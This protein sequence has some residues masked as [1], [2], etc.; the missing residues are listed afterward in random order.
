MTEG[1]CMCMNDRGGHVC[2]IREIVHACMGEGSWA[3]KYMWRSKELPCGAGSSLPVYISF[4]DQ[5]LDSV[6]AQQTP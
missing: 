1:S 3:R 5:T 6:L 2:I 4:S